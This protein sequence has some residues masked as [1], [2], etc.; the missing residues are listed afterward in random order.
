MRLRA[1]ICTQKIKHPDASRCKRFL[2]PDTSFVQGLLGCTIA[3]TVITLAKQIIPYKQQMQAPTPHWLNEQ[4][5][6]H[7]SQDTIVHVLHV[8]VTVVILYT[9]ILTEET[10]VYRWSGGTCTVQRWACTPAGPALGTSQAAPPSSDG[11]PGAHPGHTKEQYGQVWLKYTGAPCK[12]S[13][14]PYLLNQ[15]PWLLFIS[16]RN[17]VRLL[18]ESGY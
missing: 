1:C 2:H 8:P 17:F 18:F 4:E 15:T 10:P 13:R 12:F 5:T 7:M 14:L 11:L 6:W 16:S 9:H 3:F